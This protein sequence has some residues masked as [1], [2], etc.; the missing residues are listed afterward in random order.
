MPLLVDDADPL[1]VEQ[2]ATHT[3]PLSEAPSAYDNFQKKA[4]GTVKVVFK[5]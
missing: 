2:F 1:G 4:D 3:V 5:P